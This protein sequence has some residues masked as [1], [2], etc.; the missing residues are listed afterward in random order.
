[1]YRLFVFLDTNCLMIIDSP[2]NIYN[3]SFVF[4]Y[5]KILVGNTLKPI[6][7]FFLVGTSQTD[8]HYEH[9]ML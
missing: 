9:F 7:F 8:V 3:F 6:L 4:V 2:I 5:T 1:M